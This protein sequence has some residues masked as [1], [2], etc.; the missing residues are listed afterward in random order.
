MRKDIPTI[1]IAISCATAL[2]L[3]ACGTL[4]HLNNPTRSLPALDVANLS[5]LRDIPYETVEKGGIS[6]SYNLFFAKSNNVSG[7]RLTLIFRNNTGLP[8]ALK[9][10]I[11]L[12]DAG[13]FLI[14]PY[15]HES[16]VA[17]ATSL[18]GTAVPPAPVLARNTLGDAFAQGVAQGEARRAANDKEEG[19]LMLRWAN[20]FWLKNTYELPPN[21]AASGT[22]FFPAATV[23]RL[24][25]RLAVEIGGQKFEFVTVSK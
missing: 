9:P 18:A 17:E 23:G 1:R 20:S 6:V 3:G 15:T 12:Q 21:T 24:P 2:V 7:Y 22:L 4:Q 5:S 8:Q 14:A 10:V 13:G 11:S 25:L 16:F 19:R